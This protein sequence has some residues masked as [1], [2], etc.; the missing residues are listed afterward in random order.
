[1]TAFA[2]V[3]ATSIKV[4]NTSGWK[5]G[6]QIGIAPSF[7]GQKQFEKVT[8]TAINSTNVTF[9][10]ALQYAHYGDVNPTIVR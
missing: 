7:T 9:T 2:D 6:D 3:G 1:M 4:A 10:P 8:I 5:V